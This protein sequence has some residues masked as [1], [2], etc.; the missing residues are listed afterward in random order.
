MYFRRKTTK[1]GRVLQLVESYRNAEA[2]PRQRIVVSLGDLPMPENLWVDVAAGVDAELHGRPLLFLSGTAGAQD[3]VRDIAARVQREGKWQPAKNQRLGTAAAQQ[4]DEGGVDGVDDEIVDGVFLDRIDHTR[5]CS[6]GPALLGLHAWDVLGL[7]DLLDSLGFNPAQRAT[8]AALV[9]NRLVAPMSEHA[10][11]QWLPNSVLPDLLGE[12]PLKGGIDRLY[13]VG[14]RLLGHQDQIEAHLR[15]RQAQVHGLDR[16]VLLYDLTNTHFEG[17][18]ANNA[19]AKRGR[20]K[21]KRHDC[22]QVVIGMVFDEHGFE[23]AHRTF[24][25]NMSDG[26][27][28]VEMITELDRSVQ[29]EEC[30][31]SNKRPLVIMD[32]GVASEQNRRLLRQ[33]GFHYVVSE[34]RPNRKNWAEAF[35]SN[36][37]VAIPGRADSA[38]VEI[39]TIDAQF[40]DENERGEPIVVQERQVLCRSAG[41]ARKEKGMRSGAE[42]RFVT[43]LEKLSKRIAEDK[44]KAIDKIDQAIGR[45]RERRSR[46]ARFYEVRRVDRIGEEGSALF[47]RRR[48]DIYDEDDEMLGCYVLRSWGRKLSGAELWQLYMTLTNAEDAFRSLKGELGLRPNF[49]QREDRVDAHIFITVLAHHLMSFIL[50][51]LQQSGDLRCWTTI[52]RV[53]QTHCYSTV[54]VPTREAVY[55]IRKPGVPESC[56]QQIYRQF[57]I[58]LASLARSKVCLPRSKNDATL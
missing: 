3:W 55:R 40:D 52:R 42:D 14:D 18:C 19:K 25:G 31:P 47:Y 4:V 44:L 15:S 10:L 13:R 6:L 20:N 7:P 34:S 54:I 30:L 49:H 24:A 17:V 12:E 22:P 2:L 51:S 32:S 1:S 28:L 9:I 16:Q 53:L 48:D 5:S 35:R 8:A 38:A 23:L 45:L 33:H 37:F 21:Q 58:D 57:G 27:S 11:A 50:H 29:Q 56:Q 26:K 43:E 36:E 41:R 39:H 46:V